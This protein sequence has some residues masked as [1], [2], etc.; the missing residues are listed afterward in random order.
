MSAKSVR[1][2]T[3]GDCNPILWSMAAGM[4]SERW[5][6]RSRGF[7]ML[8]TITILI[9]STI[10]QHATSQT[11]N[12]AVNRQLGIDPVSG[13]ACGVLLGTDP[14]SVLVGG[15]AQICQ[16]PVPAAGNSASDATGGGAATATGLP[17]VVEE[18]LS[19]KKKRSPK[20][21]RVRRM[22]LSKSMVGWGFFFQSRA[23]V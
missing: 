22:L 11:L 1:T 14:S 3:S 12:A 10:P 17:A 18:R 5:R 21:L 16:R 8:S 4:L 23:R 6:R 20:P 19:G 13:N 2:S 9:A 15:L 7:W